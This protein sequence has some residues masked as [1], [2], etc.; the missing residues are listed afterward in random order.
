MLRSARVCTSALRSSGRDEVVVA[1]L[2]GEVLLE[3]LLLECDGVLPGGGVA[4]EVVAP[5][6]RVQPALLLALGLDEETDHIDPIRLEELEPQGEEER[7]PGTGRS[8]AA[9]A[10]AA[11]SRMPLQGPPDWRTGA[12]RRPRTPSRPVRPRT[13]AASS[14]RPSRTCRRGRTGNGRSRG[15]CPPEH[16][17]PLGLRRWQL[18]QLEPGSPPPRVSTAART[19]GASGA[20]KTMPSRSATPTGAGRRAAGGRDAPGPR[21]GI[22]TQ[23]P[24]ASKHQPW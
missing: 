9:S 1:R 4:T 2:H 6:R 22:S 12:R 21:A 19:T 20:R 23:R 17:G 11:V 14:T 13:G 15:S 8:C 5:E 3:N 16:G 24:A 7:A 18:E 10:R